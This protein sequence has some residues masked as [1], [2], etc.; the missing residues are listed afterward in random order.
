[1]S[2]ATLLGGT[3]SSYQKDIFGTHPAEA[4]E[5]QSLKKKNQTTQIYAHWIKDQ[6]KPY[7]FRLRLP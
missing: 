3:K 5:S 1:M 4:A 7:Q 6:K 2:F